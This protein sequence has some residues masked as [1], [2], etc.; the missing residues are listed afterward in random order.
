MTD[1]DDKVKP[2]ERTC[3]LA[4]VPLSECPEL[5]R[6]VAE[7]D[8]ARAALGEQQLAVDK[9]VA[10]R[11]SQLVER[12]LRLQ[13]LADRDPLT[14]LVNR[15]SLRERLEAELARHHR[16]QT[17]FSLA[18]MDIDNFKRVNDT[19]GHVVGDEVIKTVGRALAAALRRVDTVGR[20][21]GEEY[22]ILLPNTAADPAASTID[23]L[24]LLVQETRGYGPPELAVTI[25]G[26][27]SA[28]LHGEAG[29]E[30]LLARADKALYMAK[31]AGK[32]CVRVV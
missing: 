4:G 15:R 25:S 23:R 3:S 1:I 20:F 19:F 14:G 17:P 18:I 6:A 5:R 28:A 32:N 21:G 8:Q 30:P 29:W 24:R 27:V 11:I 13:E 2:G 22:L 10:E 16:Y 7:R 9:A 12:N 26:G 31:K